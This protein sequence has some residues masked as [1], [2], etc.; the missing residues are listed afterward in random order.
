MEETNFD[1]N[2]CF[3][4]GLAADVQYSDKENLISS[5]MGNRYFRSALRKFQECVDHWNESAVSLNFTVHLG[6][7][8]D[9]NTTSEKTKEDLEKVLEIFQKIKTTNYHVLGNHCLSLPRDYLASKLYGPHC[10]NGKENSVLY[11]PCFYEF[12]PFSDRV[13]S[14]KWKFIVLDGTDISI[15][16]W[17]EQ[18]ENYKKAKEWLKKHPNNQYPHAQFWNSGIG[19]DQKQWLIEQLIRAKL[20]MQRVIIFCH[21]PIVAEASSPMHLLWNHD[22]IT[23]ILES[24]DFSDTVVAY[25]CGHYHPGGYFRRRHVHYISLTGIVEVPDDTNA[26]AIVDIME[27]CIQI[28]GFGS[29]QSL[30][31][32][33]EN[34]KE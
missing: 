8:I 24:D 25:I 27:R 19:E 7:I 28:R 15:F 13:A 18:E 20:S 26:F 3:S 17:S 21:F 6:D 23:S 10:L 1:S 14:S 12:Y 29:Q 22:E 5:N 31:I 32:P 2:W 34:K 33:L 16:G 30:T 11:S 9:G 4:F